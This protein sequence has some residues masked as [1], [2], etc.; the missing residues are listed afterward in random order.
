[1]GRCPKWWSPYAL[2]WQNSF[3]E[4]ALSFLASRKVSMRSWRRA[5]LRVVRV[6]RLV[7]CSC[8]APDRRT[9]R[10]SILL[11]VRVIL[12]PL[13]QCLRYQAW[14]NHHVQASCLVDVTH[15]QLAI[16][17]KNK[18]GIEKVR[19]H[20]VEKVCLGMGGI[21]TRGLEILLSNREFAPRNYVAPKHTSYRSS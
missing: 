8:P 4:F 6:V 11:R 18:H 20:G 12:L 15:N 2:H 10:I 21:S 9:L 17:K 19:Q 14:W 13:P 3:E 5:R 1:M 16:E 7:L